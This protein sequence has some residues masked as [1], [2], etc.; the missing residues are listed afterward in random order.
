MLVATDI[1][2]RGLDIEELPHVVNFE[3]PNVPEDY[4]HRIGRTG[5][6]GSTGHA[7][8]LVDAEEG[9][10]L[11]AIEKL[12]RH[13]IERATVEGFVPRPVHAADRDDE[14][15]ERQPRRHEREQRRPQ[16]EQRHVHVRPDAKRTESQPRREAAGDR[17]HRHRRD[18]PNRA[19]APRVHD[20]SFGNRVRPVRRDEVDG[21]RLLA[22][23]GEAIGNLHHHRPEV[24]AN[25]EPRGD[26][27]RPATGASEAARHQAQPQPALFAPRPQQRRRG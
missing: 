7:V 18:E 4:V 10:F 11:R 27:R 5:R 14:R 25:R 8:S 17:P 23:R 26:V 12:I 13:P 24:D 21:N 15:R 3:M 22:V 19:Q 16:R 9:P 2:A 20:D 6:A 1:A